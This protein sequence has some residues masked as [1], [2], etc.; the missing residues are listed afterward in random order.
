MFLIATL[1]GVWLA[2]EV[3]EPNVR[4]WLFPTLGVVFGILGARRAENRRGSPI[5][6]A[7]KCSAIF[8]AILATGYALVALF[9]SRESL[10]ETDHWKTI[11]AAPLLSAI[12]VVP[13]GVIAGMIYTWGIHFWR[14]RRVRF[15]K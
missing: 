10:F 14:S 15:K 3:Q 6:G 2:F 12:V 5:W 7:A 13:F 4:I 8:A 9:Q 11:L 1:F